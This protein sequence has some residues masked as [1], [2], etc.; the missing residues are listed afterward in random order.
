MIFVDVY[1]VKSAC[2]HTRDDNGHQ[3]HG[4]PFNPHQPKSCFGLCVAVAWLWLQ[5]KHVPQYLSFN[6]M[7]LTL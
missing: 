1:I 5:S 7:S 2:R 4:K 3:N 6:T